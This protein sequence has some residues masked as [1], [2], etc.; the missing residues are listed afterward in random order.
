MS[1]VQLI[2]GIR[3]LNS[4]I[5]LWIFEFA[6]LF[7]MIIFFIIIRYIFLKHFFFVCSSQTGG[8]DLCFHLQLL[9]QILRKCIINYAIYGT[10]GVFYNENMNK[11]VKLIRWGFQNF[12]YASLV[13]IFFV[14]SVLFCCCCLSFYKFSKNHSW[15]T[16]RIK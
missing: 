6:V 15:M 5:Y 3:I 8:N 2:Y 1:Y 16:F 7:V 14:C 13:Y 9:N 11:T 4:T 12:K 10:D